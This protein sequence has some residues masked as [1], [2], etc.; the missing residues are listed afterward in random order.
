MRLL[1]EIYNP[2]ECV[3]ADAVLV[4][5]VS[6]KIPDNRGNNREFS[7]IRGVRWRN[8][9]TYRARIKYLRRDSIQKLIGKCESN[10]VK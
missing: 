6:T 5:L 8:V 9:R 7:N 4:E 1:Q 2:G 3:V 10:I